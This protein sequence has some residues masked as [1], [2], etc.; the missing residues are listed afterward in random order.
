MPMDQGPQ[1]RTESTASKSAESRPLPKGYLWRLMIILPLLL[2]AS[3]CFI[4]VN[5]WL[6][7]L[8]FAAGMAFGKL[9]GLNAML[10]DHQRSGAVK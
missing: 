1:G 8:L 6:G 3:L 2:G 10:A 4:L 7:V 5:H 9:S